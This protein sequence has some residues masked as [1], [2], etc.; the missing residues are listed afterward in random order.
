M[1]NN[2]N[3][4]HVRTNVLSP[5]NQ[6]GDQVDMNDLSPRNLHRNDDVPN[7][8]HANGNGERSGV[9]SSSAVDSRSRDER[10]NVNTTSLELRHV[11]PSRRSTDAYGS[12]SVSI[13]FGYLFEIIH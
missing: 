6:H 3:G 5:K 8:S 13:L 7:Y 10:S 12:V 9:T 4:G 1:A 2:V 11:P